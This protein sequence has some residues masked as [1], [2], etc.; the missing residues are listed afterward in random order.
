M[1][2]QALTWQLWPFLG[3]RCRQFCCDGLDGLTVFRVKTVVP[4]SRRSCER[5]WMC[6]PDPDTEEQTLQWGWVW[7][8]ESLEGEVSR[9]VEWLDHNHL[10]TLLQALTD[11]L[12]K[13]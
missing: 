5:S 2:V 3:K 8:K 9:M 10:S 12:A 13:I 1:K 11:P 7:G 4:S 6:L